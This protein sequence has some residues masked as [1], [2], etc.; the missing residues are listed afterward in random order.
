[1]QGKHVGA[2]RRILREVTPPFIPKAIKALRKT[3]RG[4]APAWEYMPRGWDAQND[5]AAIKGWDVQSILK[6]YK[7][8]WPQFLKN[9]EGARPFAFSPE[10]NDP[11][12]PDLVFHNSLM[13]YAYALAR[14]AR[15]RSSISML[16]WGG[17]IGHY[18]EFNRRLFPDLEVD[19]H[20]KE[21][22]LLAGYGQ[23]LF[24]EAHFYSDETCLQGA[25]DFV[26]ASGSLQYTEEWRELL[27]KLGAVAEGFLFITHLPTVM[28]SGSYV[29]VQRP[30]E[31]GYDTEYLGWCINR[32]EL[33]ECAE[34]AGLELVREFMIGAKPDVYKAPGQCEYRGFLFRPRA[35]DDRG[36]A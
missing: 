28:E 19:Y 4:F 26:M 12:I 3:R 7:E 33:L 31:Y 1:M 27:M 20:C 5:D 36:V 11:D 8:K 21:L 10:S 30:Y 6:T 24:P 35:A 34:S 23:Q 16:D 17:G 32:D 25:Y 9:L 13:S 14:A 2:L 15:G 22:P 18:L 29:M